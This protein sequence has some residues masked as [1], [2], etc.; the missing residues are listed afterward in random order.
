MGAL[1]F[2][3]QIDFKSMCSEH[4]RSWMLCGFEWV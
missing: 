2:M 1:F 4:I 3:C